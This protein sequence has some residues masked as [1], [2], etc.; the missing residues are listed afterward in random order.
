MS[1]NTV[2]LEVAEYI[3]SQQPG[4]DPLTAGQ[5]EYT[6]AE[7]KAVSPEVLEYIKTQQPGYI[8]PKTAGSKL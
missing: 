1:E 2:S 6:E 7:L 4:Y 3:R 8:D 5:M